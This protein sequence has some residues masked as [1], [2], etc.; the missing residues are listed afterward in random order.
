MAALRLTLAPSQHHSPVGQEHGRTIPLAGKGWPSM[1][2][3]NNRLHLVCA[4]ILPDHYESEPF[5]HRPCR[6]DLHHAQFDRLSLASRAVEKPCDKVGADAPALE[7]WLDH[8][9]FEHDVIRSFQH[10][11]RAYGRPI[12]Y[13]YSKALPRQML[14]KCRT[15][16]SLVPAPGLL[17]IF[18]HRS[19]VARVEERL[20]RRLR[21]SYRV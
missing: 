7:L 5:I 6:I 20:V 3:R 21:R 10:A 12:D 4:C 9:H 18:A 13:D 16:K 19:F 8:H 11:H 14:P 2:R 17:N 1:S 15:L